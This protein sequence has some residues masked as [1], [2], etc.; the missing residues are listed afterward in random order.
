MP[1]DIRELELASSQGFYLHVQNN[2]IENIF[3]YTFSEKILKVK[4]R[5]ELNVLS[6][7]GQ[8]WHGNALEACDYLYCVSHA[9]R[10]LYLALDC[11]TNI[12]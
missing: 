3:Q 12:K 4:W 10:K 9:W 2:I 5:S 7:L 6:F 1:I 8:L 11:M